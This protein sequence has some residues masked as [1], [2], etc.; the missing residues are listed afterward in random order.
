MSKN[1]YG[2]DQFYTKKEVVISC[3]KDIDFT[4][5]D[6]VIEPSAG[7]G[8]F[9]DEIPHKNKI[10]YDIDPKKN[11]IIKCDFLTIDHDIFSGKNVLS[12]GN[13]PFGRNSSMALKFI[14]KS[15]LFATTIAFILP[16][17][18]KKRSTIDKIPLNFEIK[19]II[20]LEDNTFLYENQ[21]F[22]VPCVWVILEKTE[23]LRTKELK[24]RP[25]KFKFTNK[26]NSNIAIRRVGVNAGKVFLN[27][28]VSESSHYFLKFDNPEEIYEKIKNLKYS[29]NDTTGP[30]SIPKNELII[31]I[32]SV[33]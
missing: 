30:R 29:S 15:A 26:E 16:K 25:E 33:I 21:N 27:T 11:N 10:G 32:E 7:D 3:L 6:I 24:I 1:K 2:F 12:I 22:N 9:F 4:L 31:M 17:G 19:K 20:D 5:Y 23:K 18:F 8:A 13:P 28:N 14:K